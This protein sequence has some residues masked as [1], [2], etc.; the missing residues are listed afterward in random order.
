MLRREFTDGANHLL[1]VV[2]SGTCQLLRLPK[3]YP[4]T[5]PLHCQLQRDTNKRQKEQARE[6]ARHIHLIL[7]LHNEKADAS[8][9]TDKLSNDCADDRES[10]SDLEAR[11]T[12]GSTVLLP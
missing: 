5:P 11:K 6:D 7:A 3:E 8:I 4:A 10:H 12:T 2:S 9:G 1:L